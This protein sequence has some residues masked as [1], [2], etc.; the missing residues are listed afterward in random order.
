L[1][2]PN[3]ILPTDLACH[4]TPNWT[5]LP[6]A[7]KLCIFPTR[8]DMDCGYLW[9]CCLYISI[10][11]IIFVPI[12]ILIRY[13]QHLLCVFHSI[14]CVGIIFDYLINIF[15]LYLSSS[16]FLNGW[17]CSFPFT[18]HHCSLLTVSSY[19]FHFCPNYSMIIPV[20]IFSCPSITF[21]VFHH[22]FSSLFH[23][24]S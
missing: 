19:G 14:L 18:F 5:K 1:T 24:L 7:V 15:V 12:L 17:T 3:L 16:L 4:R 11:G 23:N 8:K 10:A 20:H 9:G 2:Q 6:G 22:H 13:Y 21:V